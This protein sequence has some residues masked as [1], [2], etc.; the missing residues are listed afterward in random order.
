MIKVSNKEYKDYCC[1][2]G[3]PTVTPI[4]VL[5]DHTYSGY[6]TVCSEFCYNLLMNDQ[7]EE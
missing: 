1:W 6:G 5:V 2:C 7:G 4:R 3:Q